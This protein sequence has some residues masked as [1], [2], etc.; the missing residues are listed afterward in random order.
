MDATPNSLASALIDAHASNPERIAFVTSEQTLSWHDWLELVDKHAQTIETSPLPLRASGSSYQLALNAFACNLK[1]RPF[2]PVDRAHG[3]AAMPPYPDTALIISTSGSEGQPRAVCLSNRQLLAAASAANRCLQLGAGDYW[4][5][6]LP[7][8]HIGGQSILWRC[9]LAGAGVLLHEG[10]SPAAIAAAW[11]QQPVTHISLVPAMLARLV[12]EDIRPPASLRVALV[13]GAAL[14]QPL[15]ARACDAGWPIYPSYGASETAALLAV[16]Q[17][18]DGPWQAGA[19]GRPMPGS[20][21]A[22][23]ADGRIRVRGAQLMSG[24]LDGSGLSPDGWLST[25]D[26]GEIDAAGRLTVL[27]R[28]DDMLISGGSNVHPQEVESCLAAIPGIRDIAVSGCPDEVW[29]DL[30]VALVVGDVEPAS[31]LEYAAAHLR[32]AARPRQI[33][34]LAALPRNA[35]GKLDRRALRRL[36][37]GEAA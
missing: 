35:A 25:G 10:F 22:I 33:R 28:A 2:W 13:G 4:L 29:G 19:V 12:A 15:H 23:A 9:A 16:W 36:A 21:L 1:K 30:V 27:G 37:R 31:I 14:S 3:A 8:F 24:Y 26:L 5:N 7:L 6:C 18:S 17:A 20:E 11:Q 32:P 34:R